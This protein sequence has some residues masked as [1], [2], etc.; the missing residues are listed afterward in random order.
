MANRPFRYGFSQGHPQWSQR[1]FAFFL[2]FCASALPAADFDVALVRPSRRVLDAFFATAADVFRFGDFRCDRA[3]PAALFD[4]GEVERLFSVLDAF[5]A[6]FFP[7][8]LV[9]KGYLGIGSRRLKQSPCLP[10]HR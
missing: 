2:P 1:F 8:C 6:A 5:V 3:L 10:H 4:F 7:V 9:A